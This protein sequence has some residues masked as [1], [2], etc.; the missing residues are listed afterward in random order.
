MVKLKPKMQTLLKWIG[1]IL[2]LIVGLFLFFTRLLKYI[3]PFLIAF[4]I[5]M[6]IEW[7]VDFFQKKIKLSRSPAVA[8]SIILFIIVVGGILTFTFYRLTVELWKLALELSKMDFNPVIE[9]FESLFE[10]GQDLFFSLPDSLIIT[11]EESLELDASRLSR[12]AGGVSSWLMNIVLGMV[13]F[14]KFLPDVLVFIIVMFISTY[15]M[16][17]DRR[18]ISEFLSER[19][20]PLWYTKIRNLKN[21]MLIALVGFLKAQMLLMAVTFLELLIGYQILGVEYAFFFALAT[22]IVDILPVLGTGT[23]LIPTAIIYFII[24]NIPRA[25]GFLIL[26]LIIFIIRQILEPKVVGQS[27]G[28]HPLVTLMSMYI[29]LKFMGVAGM[30]LG[31]ILIIVIKAFYKAGIFPAWKT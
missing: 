2:L 9:Y 7:L 4:V 27:L 18:Q 25:L 15:F 14:A 12:I 19:I 11:I 3:A 13:E 22:A 21:D 29:G 17:R 5:M 20:P 6:S 1:I 23:V 10:R 8:I 31:P 16:S 30:F 24:G 28:L 26:Y